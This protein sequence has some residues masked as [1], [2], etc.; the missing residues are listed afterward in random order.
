[1]LH[2]VHRRIRDADVCAGGLNGEQV[3]LAAGHPEHVA[4]RAEDHLGPGGDLE[5]FVNQF[6]RRD[7]DRTA[8]AVDERDLPG[9]QFVEAEFDDGMRLAA[10]DF[11]ERPGAR[12]DAGDFVRV[13]VR[14]LG[15]AVFVE[16]FHEFG[17][18]VPEDETP[19]WTGGTPAPLLSRSLSSCISR[20]YS[21]TLLSLGLIHAA[22][23]EADVDDDV[24]ADLGFGHVSEADFFKD[25]AEVN[26]AGAHQ[27]VF[28]ADAGDFTWNSQTHCS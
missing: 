4:E 9:Q 13:F 5:R 26:F 23:G 17:G 25:A 12:R 2:R 16:V 28:A 21:K 24:I 7:A 19:A 1:M 8:G 3:G 22:E 27:W 14:G 15:I 11:H 6:E 18:P 20:R 10:A